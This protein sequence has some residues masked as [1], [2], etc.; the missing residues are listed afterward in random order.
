VSLYTRGV[1]LALPNFAASLLDGVESEEGPHLPMTPFNFAL[2]WLSQASSNRSGGGQTPSRFS[3]DTSITGQ[4]R[5]FAKDAKG[6][7]TRPEKSVNASLLIG[8][9]E[10]VKYNLLA[11]ATHLVH[12]SEIQGTAAVSGAIEIFLCVHNN[13]K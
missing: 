13:Q 11:F 3:H 10:V 5:D 1:T 12:Y 9:F 7:A 6:C 8:P 4:P 2:R